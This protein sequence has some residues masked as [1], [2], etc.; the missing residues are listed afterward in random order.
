MTAQLC[1]RFVLLCHMH[2]AAR[3]KKY[4]RVRR[5]NRARMPPA[6]IGYAAG[7]TDA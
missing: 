6:A 3:K 5:E 7:S 2:N 1:G 4:R